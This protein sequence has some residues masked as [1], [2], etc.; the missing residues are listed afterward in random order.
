[1]VKSVGKRKR[2][3]EIETASPETESALFQGI[4]SKKLCSVLADDTV[5]GSAGGHGHLTIVDQL[6]GSRPKMALKAFV[7]SVDQV[8]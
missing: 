2:G 7:D 6:R 8:K 3:Q 1:M 5:P 4:G